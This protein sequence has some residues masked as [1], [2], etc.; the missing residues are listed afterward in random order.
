MSWP[1]ADEAV[2]AAIEAGAAGAR[3]TGGGFGGSV[4]AL[5]PADRADQVRAGGNQAIHPEPL[6]SPA[7][8]GRGALRRRPPN[9]QRSGLV[10]QRLQPGPEGGGIGVDAEQVH[11]RDLPR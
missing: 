8:P 5:V 11:G 9:R 3:M 7:L 10:E 4:V 6:A 2:E 1:Q